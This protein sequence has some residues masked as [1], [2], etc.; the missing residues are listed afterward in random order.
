MLEPDLTLSECFQENKKNK[1]KYVVGDSTSTQQ[2]F[3]SY[4]DYTH[5]LIGP[6]P[7]K[8]GVYTF[9]RLGALLKGI[10]H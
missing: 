10:H 8:T 4:K 9:R 1:I 6:A 2:A 7:Y 3:L 5:G